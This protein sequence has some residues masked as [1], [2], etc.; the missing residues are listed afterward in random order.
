[1]QN[2]LRFFTRNGPF[3]TWLV[4]AIL[5]LILLFQRNPYQ[6]SVWLGSANRVSGEIYTATSAVTGYF[7]LRSINEELL[8]RIGQLEEENIKLRNAVRDYGEL[9]AMAAD[10][11]CPY[12]YTI[13]HVVNNS[14]TQ[15]ENYLT[16]DRGEADSVRVGM[17]VAD[18]NGVVGI[19]SQVSD[20][21]SLAISVLNP[22]L[23]L[24]VCLKGSESSGTLVWDGID[25][26]YALLVDV[27]RNVRYN[28]GD[29][30]VTTGYGD[31][32]PRGVQVGYLRETAASDDNNFLSFKVE[33]STRFDRV[34]NVHLIR[35]NEPCPF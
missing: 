16:L 22:K 12:T 33:L 20:H 31:S 29:T 13:A 21:F 24:S 27:P 35:N 25:P 5:S 9:S 26:C 34:N 19:V 18:Q 11:C 15:A 17:A 2:L 14:V 8:A 10:T 23:R 7:G 30:V 28:L 32:F 4:L 1:M 3:F 6:R